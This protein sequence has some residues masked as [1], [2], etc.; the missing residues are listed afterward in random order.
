MAFAALALCAA[1]GASAQDLDR[2][3][4]VDPIRVSGSIST[5]GGIYG[6][7]MIG[8][9]R[10]PFSYSLSGTL[11]L[12]IY[13]LALPLSFSISDKERNFTQPFN[14]FGASPRYKW[15]T[16]HLGYR[17][18]SFSPFTLAGHQMLGAGVELN[19]GS[20]RL[21]FMTG[22]LNRAVE[23]DTNSTIEIPAYERTGFSGKLGYGSEAN[24]LDL[25]VLKAKDDTNSIRAVASNSDL[26]PAENLVLGASARAT[27]IDG[28]SLNADFAVSDYTRDIR[29]DLL[30]L[31]QDA[32][33]LGDA[34]PPR[35]STQIY[36][37]LTAGMSLNIETFNLQASYSRIDPD[38]RS[39]GAYYLNNDLESFTLAPSLYLTGSS[40]SINANVSLQKD[41]I[42][43]KK[44]A[45]TRRLTPILNIS[46]SPSAA[47]GLTVQASDMRTSQSAGNRPLNDTLRMDQHSP[48]LLIAPRYTID[49]SIVSHS[50]YA[51]LSLQGVVDNNSFTAGYSEYSSTAADLSYTLSLPASAT[52]LNGSIGTNRMETAGTEFYTAGV[53]VGGTQGLA[54]GAIN[55]NGTVGLSFQGNGTVVT[56]SA[57]GA[58][59]P[60]K[61]HTVNLNLSLTN[62]SAS[63]TMSRPFNEYTAVLNYAYTF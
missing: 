21:G 24:H 39:M 16:A 55:L 5:R 34:I 2:V 44:Q 46:W 47:F 1:R 28:L 57:G 38:Y 11:N 41:N 61:H 9:H 23:D 36:T 42:Q 6:T 26:R 13:D 52:T 7:D 60:E 4:E 49:D 56:G 19:P 27:V 62:S 8:R 10:D 33:A 48:S 50:F 51:T 22:R 18:I 40:L 32:Q 43:G 58:W 17:N 15:A 30:D 45:T 3:G 54:G 25:I 59:R 53:S 31:D 63:D 20:F 37:A 12:D 14:Q 35:A 29:S